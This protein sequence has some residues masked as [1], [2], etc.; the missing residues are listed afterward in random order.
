LTPGSGLGFSWIPDSQPIYSESL[1]TIFVVK[2]T[3]ILC[4]LS[5]FFLYLLKYKIMYNFV[6]LLA[7][8]KG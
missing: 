8:K 3:I 6:K 1:M 4:H 2:I 5:N 7:T